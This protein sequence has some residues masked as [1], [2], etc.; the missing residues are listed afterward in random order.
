MKKITLLIISIL[1]LF[2]LASCKEKKPS[3]TPLDTPIN[4]KINEVGLITWDSV[5]NASG[6]LVMINNQSFFATTNSYQVADLSSEFTYSVAALGNAS[7]SQSA[8]SETLTFTPATKPIIPDPEKAEISVAIKG[9]SEVKANHAIILEAVVTGGETN[10]VSWKIKSGSEYATIDENGRLTAG[11]VSKDCIIEVVCESKEDKKATASKII[12]IVSKPILTQDM[13]DALNCD[14]IGFEGYVNISLYTIGTFEK[15]EQTYSTVIKTSM[16]GTNW[17]A[18]Y[19][20]GD[21][22]TKMGVYYKNY[23]N[24]ACQVGVSF[25]N[26]EEYAPLVENETSV[27][28]VNAGLYNSLKNLNVEQFTFIE[29]TW[30][31]E[32]TGGNDTLVKRIISSSNPYDFVPLG[33]SLIIE[34]DE[35]LG[36]YSKS[37]P[38]YGILEG[39][40]AIQELTVA[41]NL[42][43][44]VQV[45]TINKYSHE[46][47]HDDLQIAINNMQNLTSYTLDFK[48]IVGSYLASGYQQDGFVELITD[49]DCYYTPYAVG[50][51]EY[52]NEEHNL[53]EGSSYG[54]HKFSDTLY[55]Q[56]AVD[57]TK[58]DG[59]FMAVRAYEEDFAKAKPT[60]KFA[61]EIFRSYYYDEEEKTTTYY[62]DELMT[63]VASTFY[64]GVGNDLNLYGIFATTGYVS[65]TEPFNPYVVVKDDYIIEAGFYFYLGSM[66][67]VVELKYD[68]FNETVIPSDANID[69]EIRNVPTLWSELTIIE[70]GEGYSTDDDVELNALVFLK[71]FFDDEEIGT[72]L[73]FFGNVLGDT[74]GFGLTQKHQA[75]DSTT[76]KDSICF[77]Y[78]VPL[79]INY[80]I[81]SSLEKI[82]EY[83]ISLGFTKNNHDEFYKDNIYIAP[84]DSSLDLLIYVWKN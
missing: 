37:E 9:S 14:K 47:I 55:N 11:E 32:Y 57:T 72:K 17:Y 77:Y 80:T 59:S 61:A 73:P 40:K 30:R 29:E 49:A 8:Q 65:G 36:I 33:F 44:T 46:D 13:L 24:I 63:Q 58:N 43:D 84:V 74:Y 48:E 53:K 18:E 41:I 28:W 1:C 6:Y 62:A 66:Y 22:Y 82:A 45:P 10:E 2:T 21:T 27:T 19:E 26:E 52:G 20:N 16:D 81:D 78:D 35:I 25:L 71:D 67:G 76:P 38:D 34:E 68:A 50:Y 51:D 60:F 69:F 31:Y 39:Y 3:V 42:G 79:D 56:Y 4:V 70:S 12:T 54:F 5:E 15:L 75:S 7:Y 83:L 23:N 64:F